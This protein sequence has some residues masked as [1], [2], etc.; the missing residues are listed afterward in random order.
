[1]IYTHKEQF[2]TKPKSVIRP[3]NVFFLQLLAVFCF[4]MRTDLSGGF[5]LV[6]LRY[7]KWK[8]KRIIS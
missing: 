1:M 6:I 8:G 2:Y 4:F 7:Q 5:P 3:F